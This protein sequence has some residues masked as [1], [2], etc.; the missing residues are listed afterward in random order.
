MTEA[1][2]EILKAGGHKNSLGR[3]SEVVNAVLSDKS[4]LNE[5]YE[6]I[7]DED[8]WVRMR[9]VDSFEKICRVNPDW[10][11][12]YTDNLIDSVSKIDQASI[13]WHLAELFLQ[14]DLNETQ[15][16]KAVGIMKSNISSPNTDWIV[17]SNTMTT[18]YEF[19]KQDKLA[20]SEVLPLLKIQLKHRSNA[21]VKRANKYIDL[22]KD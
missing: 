20:R 18:L 4:R 22:L 14:L 11:Q 9:A 21:V 3:A 16:N 15:F 19:V 8:A 7:F 13:H 17:A 5:L 2:S 6:C 1:F 10:I 12:S